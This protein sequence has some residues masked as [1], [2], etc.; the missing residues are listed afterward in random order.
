MS[1]QGQAAI[2]CPDVS[3]DQGPLYQAIATAIS[4]DIRAGVLRPGQRLPPQRAL[5]ER[6]GI[7]FTTVSR[8]YAAAGKQGLVE[9]RV[10][11]GTF[12]CEPPSDPPRAAAPSVP[13]DRR[14]DRSMNMPPLFEDAALSRQMLDDMQAVQAEAGVEALMRYQPLGGSPDDQRAARDWLAS[15]VALDSYAGLAICSGVQ[16]A[17]WSILSQTVQPG[18]TV[19]CEDFTYP[20]FLSIAR[21]MGLRVVP[22]PMNAT[23]L[24]PA[25]LEEICRTERPRLLYTTPTLHNPTGATMPE[26]QRRAIAGVVRAHDLA[27]IEDDAYGVVAPEAP[28]PLTRF[29]PQNCWYVATLSKCLAPSLRVCFAIPPETASPDGFWRALHA[30]G[31]LVSPI[32]ARL[33]TR[34]FATGTATRL[35]DAIRAE[36]RWRQAAFAERFPDVPMGQG[37]FHVWLRL[38]DT[39]AATDLAFAMRDADL[40][41]VPGQAFAPVAAP[42]AVRLAL[43]VSRDRHSYAAALT[44]L[45]DVLAHPEQRNWLVV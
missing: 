9:G 44:S 14:L 26:A 8:A 41:V 37:A 1:A 5:A 29:A 4:R 10:G 23:G 13:V 19:C 35:T 17:V 21:Q 34:W 38:P 43:G 3:A 20:G 6:L 30:R 45:A 18:D 7:D 39:L 32:S 11:Q 31:G 36:T 12:V 22:V 15:H 40:G 25:A 27:V 28:P 2:W 33:A 24:D 42:N 16:A